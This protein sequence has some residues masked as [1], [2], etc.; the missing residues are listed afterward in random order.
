MSS[1][2]DLRFLPTVRPSTEGRTAAQGR[3]R[4]RRGGRRTPTAAGLRALFATRTIDLILTGHDHDLF[5]NFDDATRWSNSS[6][7]AHFVTAIDVTIAVEEQGGRRAT[8]WWPQFRAI[9]TATVTPDPEVAAAVGSTRR[10]LE[11]DRRRARHHRDRARQP[12]CH[13]AHAGGRDRQPDRRRH[14]RLDRADV[15]ITNGGGIRAGKVFPPGTSI[16]RRDILAELP[17]DNRRVLRDHRRGPSR[18]AIENGLSQLPN[19]GG[20]FPQ[21]SGLTIQ[22]D[23]SR[24]PG[25]RVTSMEVGGKPLDET[26]YTVATNDFMSR[27][28]DGY[29]MFVDGRAAAARSRR[30]AARQRCDGLCPQT[31]HGE[32]GRRRADRAE[33]IP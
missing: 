8:T 15:A 25:S 10:V 9:D 28:G 30:S 4:L 16:T 17:F 6:Y 31:R 23:I 21:V 7:D 2:G 33:V 20:R 22:V 14:A 3:R 11:R 26:N 24:P 19:A 12:Q 1:P 29:T 18:R 27:G 13:R 32:D 5:I